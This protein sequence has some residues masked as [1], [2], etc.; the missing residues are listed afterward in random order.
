[1]AKRRKSSISQLTPAQVKAF[2]SQLALESRALEMAQA[3][4]ER[5]Q[6]AAE[7]RAQFNAFEQLAKSYADRAA[8]AGRQFDVYGGQV[9]AQRQAALERLASSAESGMGGIS[10]AREQLMRDLVGSQAYQTTPLVELSQVQNP[11]L[12]GL[13]AEGAS[14]AGVEAQSAQDAQIA[15]QLASLAR[16]AATQLNVGEQN[17]LNALRNAGAYSAAQAQQQLAAMRAMGTQDIGSEYD[18]LA[19]QIAQQRLG[20]VGDYQA[21]SQEAAA[22]AQGFAPVDEADYATQLEAARRAAMQSIRRSLPTGG[23]SGS[24]VNTNVSQPTGGRISDLFGQVSVPYEKLPKGAKL[25]PQQ[26]KRRR[27]TEDIIALR[28]RGL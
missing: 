24:S 22:K 5:E 2:E 18:K 13:A 27:E 6:A 26:L 7:R 8:E 9:E 28:Q 3:Q 25:T 4:V 1:M 16:G 23:G 17:Y 10:A 12:V 20:E 11:L 15:A 21:R 14:T 19:Q